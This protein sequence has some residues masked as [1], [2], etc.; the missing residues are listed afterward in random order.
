MECDVSN[1]MTDKRRRGFLKAS[2][3]VLA[4]TMSSAP[5]MTSTVFA[6]DQK[7]NPFTL[8]YGGALTKNEPG[9][10]PIHPVK[11]RLNGPDTVDTVY[12]PA[13]YD[14]GSLEESGVG[15]ES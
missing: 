8:V 10:V 9:K 13:G 12:T 11:Y 4:G 5:A 7:P 3:L 14:T 6:A 1:Q 15:Q 2:A